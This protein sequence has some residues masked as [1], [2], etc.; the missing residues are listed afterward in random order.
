MALENVI[1][2]WDGT[3]AQTL[4]LWLKGYQTAFEGRGLEF[5]DTVIVE[6]FFHNHDAV[7]ERYPE[8]EFPD[9]AEETR[10]SVFEEL[11]SVHLYEGSEELF[12]GLERDGKAMTLVT[13]SARHMLER[14]LDAHQLAPK[15]SSI[16]AGDDG[17]G[18]KPSVRPFEETLNRIGARPENTLII[19]DTHVDIQAGQSLGCKTC[20]FAP[21]H[22]SLFHDFAAIRELAPDFE[23]TSLKDILDIF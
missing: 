13:S 5:S 17:F 3:L 16:I 23:V 11:S 12:A 14:G 18:H 21:D 10:N 7:L 1:L 19:G 8:M 20:W 6:E 2:D 9:I 22:N 4:D 15:F